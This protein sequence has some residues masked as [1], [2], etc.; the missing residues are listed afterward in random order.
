[1]KKLE[2]EAMGI[3]SLPKKLT[4]FMHQSID[5]TDYF[6]SLI[7]ILEVNHSQCV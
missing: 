4:I 6:N 2:P 3:K 5:G 1:M 7:D